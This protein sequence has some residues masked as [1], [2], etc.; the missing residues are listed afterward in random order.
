MKE[1][2]IDLFYTHAF[3]DVFHVACFLLLTKFSLKIPC[4]VHYHNV[5]SYSL[6]H[7]AIHQFCIATEWLKMAD[8]VLSLSRIDCLYFQSQGMKSVY[9]PNPPSFDKLPDDSEKISDGK[10]VLFLAR[11]EHSQKR[12]CTNYQI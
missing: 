7:N 10:T 2:N 1:Y 9:L 4:F 6:C 11:I 5:F 12:P 3:G 8:L